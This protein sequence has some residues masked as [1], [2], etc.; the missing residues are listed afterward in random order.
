MSETA[1]AM[2]Q[3]TEHTQSIYKGVNDT[4][5]I[6][7]KNAELLSDDVAHLVMQVLMFYAT[8]TISVLGITGNVFSMIILLKHGLHKCSNILLFCLAVS[9]TTFLVAFNNV[10]KILNEVT[11]VPMAWAYSRQAAHASYVFYTFFHIVDYAVGS[12]SLAI[13]M[14]ITMERLVAVYFPMKFSVIVTPFRTWSAVA[15]VY[16]YWLVVYIYSSFW[17]EFQYKYD[18]KLNISMG[19]IGLSDRYYEEVEVSK[20]LD[21]VIRY[22]TL[23]IPPCFTLVGCILISVKIKL[24]SVKRQKMTSAGAAKDAKSNRTSKMLLAVCTMYTVTCGILTLPTY[25]PQYGYYT[26]TGDAPNNV[27]KIGYQVVN[28]VLC[29]NG[30]CN[31]IVYVGMNKNFRDT[32]KSL[33]TRCRFKRKPAPHSQKGQAQKRF[34]FKN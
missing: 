19:I 25:L 11:G 1:L 33:F 32:W 29:I 16:A 7:E 3:A 27:G 23:K 34:E 6:K 30:S 18:L 15:I 24:A 5:P 20:A 14:L 13:P 22:L 17:F 21:E 26:M 4:S 28:M 2:T 9:D 10:P 31:F 12:S 8:P